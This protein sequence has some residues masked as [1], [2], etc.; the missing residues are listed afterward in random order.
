MMCRIIYES[1]EIMIPG[2]FLK[3]I[4][5]VVEAPVNKPPV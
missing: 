4:G 5:E 2:L 3:F 1:I